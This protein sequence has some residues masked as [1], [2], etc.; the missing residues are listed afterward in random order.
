MTNNLI[1]L[2]NRENALLRS[3]YG[4]IPEANTELND[5]QRDKIKAVYENN[6]SAHV[7]KITRRGT[8]LEALSLKTVF[9]EYRGQLIYNFDADFVVPQVDDALAEM[10]VE[11]NVGKQKMSPQL[12]KKIYNRIEALGGAN[13]LWS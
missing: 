8:E 11:W 3:F 13:L 4:R 6:G 9:S 5:I 12:F 1:E 10:I 7:G 2:N